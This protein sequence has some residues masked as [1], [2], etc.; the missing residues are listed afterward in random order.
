MSTK[1]NKYSRDYSP[2]NNNKLHTS[3]FDIGQKAFPYYRKPTKK[4]RKSTRFGR[5][6]FGNHNNNS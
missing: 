3:T 1:T 4:S 5:P 2:W 6:P